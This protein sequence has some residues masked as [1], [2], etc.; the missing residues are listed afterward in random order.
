MDEVID[1]YA[2]YRLLSLDNDP[3][4]RT[5]TVEVAHEAILRAWERL[6]HWLTESRDEIKLQRQ[7]SAMAAEWRESKQ[8]NSFLA[9]GARLEQFEKWVADTKLALTR[10]E[11]A[12]LDASIT[13]RALE[14][15]A[16]VERKAHETVLEQR[17]VGRL[18]AL[19]AVMFIALIGAV[20]LIG[21]AV[22]QSQM[23]QR[24]AAEAQNLALINGS[25]GGTGKR[26]YRSGDCCWH[27]KRSCSTQIPQGRRSH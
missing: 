16:E 14:Q 18:R 11:R 4:T 25:S 23:A 1:T 7:L 6:R 27:C 24:N 2:E 13:H 9:R 10:A 12:Y 26:Q 8:D 3:G 17:S 15:Q 19:V 20:G 22:N 5:P 21:L